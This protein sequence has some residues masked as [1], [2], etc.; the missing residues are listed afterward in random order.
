MAQYAHTGNNRQQE[1]DLFLED[2]FLFLDDFL[3]RHASFWNQPTLEQITSGV[4][5]EVLPDG[6]EQ[7]LQ[8]TALF[9]PGSA[10]SPPQGP[11]SSGSLAYLPACKG[12]AP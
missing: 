2:I 9:R 12:A 10:P 6:Q 4:W 5:T 1:E 3:E 11:L 7:L 8:A